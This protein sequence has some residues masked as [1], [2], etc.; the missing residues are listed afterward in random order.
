MISGMKALL[1]SQFSSTIPIS[2]NLS[3]KYSVG[4]SSHL[5]AF[6]VC[7][8]YFLK[9]FVRTLVTL[10][11]M[12]LMLKPNLGP[13]VCMDSSSLIMQNLYVFSNFPYFSALNGPTLMI[14]LL[15]RSTLIVSPDLSSIR[16]ALC[17]QIISF[18]ILIWNVQLISQF[19]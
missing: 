19:S 11:L 4:L 1:S 15:V 9:L 2:L 7:S 3:T 5:Q 12:I 18:L 14:M 10:G 17:L 16:Q 8:K 6:F 13:K